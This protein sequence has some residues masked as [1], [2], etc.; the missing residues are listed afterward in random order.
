MLEGIFCLTP[1]LLLHLNQLTDLRFM[2]LEL[3]GD[4]LQKSL[5]TLK[6]HIYVSLLFLCLARSSDSQSVINV[7]GQ[8]Q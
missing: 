8:R 7:S 1:P 6:S 2:K 4:S 5:Q 3:G